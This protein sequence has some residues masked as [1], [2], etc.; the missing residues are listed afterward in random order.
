MPILDQ[1]KWGF[2]MYSVNKKIESRPIIKSLTRGRFKK[3]F[4]IKGNYVRFWGMCDITAQDYQIMVPADV[5]NA[6]LQ[7]VDRRSYKN[8]RE[9]LKNMPVDDQR[10]LLDGITPK[11]WMELVEAVESIGITEPLFYSNLSIKKVTLK[12]R[13]P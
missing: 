2:N 9:I 12:N 10:F 8:I 7:C 11:G 5:F 13:L 3:Y 6:F 1:L 4:E